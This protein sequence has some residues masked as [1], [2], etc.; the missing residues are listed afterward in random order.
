MRIFE[1]EIEMIKGFSVIWRNSPDYD[2]YLDEYNGDENHMSG[3]D[4]LDFFSLPDDEKEA[5]ICWIDYAL[6]PDNDNLC[7]NHSYSLKHIY[8]RDMGKYVTN[9]QFKGA[10]I[11]Y[12]FDPVNPRELNCY[13]RVKFDADILEKYK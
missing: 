3:N 4:P 13:Y 12:G 7:P 1:H 8:E 2:K 9:G 11:K 6:E 5:L 10:M